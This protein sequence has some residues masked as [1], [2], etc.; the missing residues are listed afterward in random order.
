MVFDGTFLSAL[1]LLAPPAGEL[2]VDEA[3]AR[4][5]VESGGTRLSLPFDNGSHAEIPVSIEVELLEPRGAVVSRGVRTLSLRP[6]RMDVSVPIEPSLSAL[7]PAEASQ[8]LYYRSRY[9]VAPLSAASEIHPLDGTISVSELTSDLFELDIVHAEYA[10]AGRLHQV[11]VATRHPATGNPVAD[12]R[13]EGSLAGDV[14][15][16]GRASATTDSEGIAALDLPLAGDVEGSAMLTVRAFKGP[17]FL[18]KE[19]EVF[20]YRAGIPLLTTDKSLYQPGQTLHMRLL[21]FD[22]SRRAIDGA[23]AWFKVLDEEQR[24]VFAS[25]ATTSRFGIASADW[26]IPESARLGKYRVET[27]LES[28]RWGASTASKEVRISRYEIPQFFVEAAPDKPFYLYGEK[29]QVEVHAQYLFGEPVEQGRVRVSRSEKR[30]WDYRRGRWASESRRD[31]TGELDRTGR[32]VVEIDLGREW[33][34]L[35]STEW[36][37][38]DDLNFQAYVTDAGTGRTEERRFDVRIT[39]EPIHVY[40]IDGPQWSAPPAAPF[41]FYLSTFSADGSPI[42][43]D[44]TVQVLGESDDP[45]PVLASARTNRFGVAKVERFTIPPGTRRGR[46]GDVDVLL[47]ARDG[48]GRIGR[49]TESV[50]TDDE[51]R[52]HVRMDRTLHRPGETIVASIEAPPEVP[53][54]ALFLTRN[55]EVLR[56][57]VVDPKKGEREVSIPYDPSFRGGLSLVAFPLDEQQAGMGSH[58]VVFPFDDELRV[59]IE[60]QRKHYRPGELAEIQFDVRRPDG[61]TTESALGVTVVDRALLE[62]ERTDEEFGSS[63]WPYGW[64]WRDWLNYGETLGA[65]S[66]KDVL[67]LPSRFPDGMDLVAE[68]L[69]RYPDF[70]PGI[71]ETERYRTDISAIFNDAIAAELAPLAGALEALYRDSAHPATLE[72]LEADLARVQTRILDLADP[73]ESPFRSEFYPSGAHFVLSLASNGPDETEGTEDD[74]VPF[75]RFWN[76]F[77]RAGHILDRA[78]TEYHARTGRFIRDYRTLRAE[79]LSKGFDTESLL[80]PWGRKYE[81]ELGVEERYYFVRVS[82][83]DADV[84]KNRIDYFAETRERIQSLL[85]DRLAATG[86]WPDNPRSLEAFLKRNGASLEKERDPWGRPYSVDFTTE[87][88]YADRIEVLGRNSAPERGKTTVTPVTRRL[89]TIHIRSGGPGDVKEGSFE[90]ASF[91]RVMEESEK[92]SYAPVARVERVPS[93]DRGAIGGTVTDSEDGVLPGV[94]V[95]LSSDSLNA[96]KTV[97]GPGGDYLFQDLPGGIYTIVFDLARFKQLTLEEVPVLGGEKTIANAVL[98]LASVGETV[99]VTGESPA[100]HTSSSAAVAA[101][102]ATGSTLEATR[103]IMTPR[104]RQYFPETLWWEPELMTD[105]DGRARFA[106]PLA[107]NVSTW[108]LS[109]IASNVDG[110]VGLAET[111][112][113]AFQPFFIDLDPPAVLTVGDR[114]QQP[115][116]LRSYLEEPLQ[117][118]VALEDQPWFRLLG[119]RTRRESVPA[120][121]TSRSLFDLEVSAPSDVARQR[122]TA[123]SGESSEASDAVEKTLE[124]RPDGREITATETRIF[125]ENGARFSLEIPEDALDGSFRGELRIYPSLI[126][127]VLESLDAVRQRPYGC[128]E[129]TISAAYPA[130]LLLRYQRDHGGEVPGLDGARREVSL[131]YQALLTRQNPDGGFSYWNREHPDVSLTAYAVGFL[132]EARG[133]LDV[134]ERME[135][136]ARRWLHAQQKEDGRWVDDLRYGK[137][138][139]E[140]ALVTAV[141]TRILAQT[142]DPDAALAL[143]YLAERSEEIDEPYLIATFALAA[144]AAGQRERAE[145]A[146]DRLRSLARSEGSGAYWHLQTNTPFYGW[147]RAGR[148]ETTALATLALARIGAAPDESLIDQGLV[149]LLRNKDRFG[150]WYSTQATMRVVETLLELL[151]KERWSSPSSA[152]F[153]ELI[154]NGEHAHRVSLPAANEVRGPIHRDLSPWLFQGAN[155]LRL[156]SDRAV[157]AAADLVSSYYRGWPSE[158]GDSVESPDLR[159]AVRYRGLDSRVGDEIEALVEAERVG[160][161]GYGMLLAEVGIPPGADVDHSSIEDALGRDGLYGYEV[162]PDRVIFYLWPRGGGARFSFSF[163]PRFS[164]QAKSAPSRLYDYYNPESEVVLAPTIFRVR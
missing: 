70:Y 156:V 52:I 98:S 75:R 157:S 40:W 48:R 131:A 81:F 118:D 95:T 80:D 27:G 88:T 82:S 6:G 103:P 139:W 20:V 61:S 161:R 102:A 136:K 124:I 85:D 151:P 140:D 101:K 22:A 54:L 133:F 34:D 78:V 120:G 142:G 67:R 66:K 106:L 79:L 23:E 90:V 126:A 53:R 114:I 76:H 129:Q 18:E 121:G 160:F 59:S 21:A 49:S 63:P 154:V 39:R 74:F 44:V 89:R 19:N 86:T 92:A 96:W 150:G 146:V 28:E 83:G 164:M 147:G 144:H 56:A 3:A 30:Y 2:R 26:P 72:E 99:T 107:D 69:F 60:T 112:I 87:T 13:I 117:V 111:D 58:P 35:D 14:R 64:Y 46:W 93:R 125:D 163:R 65:V 45:G 8:L 62:R 9:R 145:R 119:E 116:L 57:L 141:V 110:E 16:L 130:L 122:V 128:T 135:A 51:P 47:T 152:S 132:A 127:H 143:D 73:W 31:W 36:W 17:A 5:S 77:G 4:L 10:R 71:S 55:D 137:T 91:Q 94:S 162:L 155:E 97:T 37:R 84:W 123:L 43:C 138:G 105:G 33:P 134:D 32:F 100:I 11:I 25:D 159:F 109:T 115:V 68:I 1:I 108:N 42:E 113:L 29:A 38:S 148:L 12:V 153:L 149:F 41:D 7:D 15:V 50:W 24:L 158:T 104:L